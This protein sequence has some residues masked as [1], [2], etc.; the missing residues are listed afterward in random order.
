[1]ICINPNKTKWENNPS[2][3]S[4]KISQR[5]TL[6][7]G[8]TI[9]L[10]VPVFFVSDNKYP[11][12]YC[13][14]VNVFKL[15]AYKLEFAGMTITFQNQALKIAYNGATYAHAAVDTNNSNITIKVAP[16]YNLYSGV[17]VTMTDFFQRIMNVVKH[18]ATT[19]MDVKLTALETIDDCELVYYTQLGDIAI[20]GNFTKACTGLNT[21]TKDL[22]IGAEKAASTEILQA[23][24]AYIDMWKPKAA[25]WQAGFYESDSGT[26]I[27]TQWKNA[28]DEF[29]SICRNRQIYPIAC[30]MPNAGNH[31]HN[32]KNQYIRAL[33]DVFVDDVALYINR[34]YSG[35]YWPMKSW[36]PEDD[37]PTDHGYWHLACAIGR[38]PKPLN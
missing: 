37:A 15:V 7:S 3:G 25:I 2:F 36:S 1:M 38:G 24:K 30:T 31:N 13:V 16:S 19:M 22:F 21:A 32:P 10:K 4:N 5:K 8:G 23:F 9:T 6:S 18:P 14:Q 35:N 29:L 34:E 20:F 11:L 28:F 27:N 33:E 26:S 17:K 12:E